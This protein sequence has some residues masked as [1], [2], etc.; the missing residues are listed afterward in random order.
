MFTSY[1]KRETQDASF[2]RSGSDSR[3]R[4]HPFETRRS[5]D[6][7]LKINTEMQADGLGLLSRIST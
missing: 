4:S 6:K 2:S 3:E 1:H 7:K 5:G